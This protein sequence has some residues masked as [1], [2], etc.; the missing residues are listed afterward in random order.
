[1]AKLKS[2]PV[3][4]LLALLV[5]SAAQA[6]VAIDGSKTTCDQLGNKAL[7]P[8]ELELWL[9]GYD[10]GKR[11]ESTVDVVSLDRNEEKV[12]E[13]CNHNP[14]V[15]LVQAIEIT[16]NASVSNPMQVGDH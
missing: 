8:V 15:N 1:M 10:A 16:H 5:V 2:L 11:N 6:Q 14:D 4:F 12:S 3:G 7:N 9:S 13:Y